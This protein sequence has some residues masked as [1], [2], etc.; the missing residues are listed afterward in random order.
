MAGIRRRPAARNWIPHRIPR[1]TRD[2]T[3]ITII[4]ATQWKSHSLRMMRSISW[5]LMW[6]VSQRSIHTV[7]PRGTR[8]LTAI[9]RMSRQVRFFAGA[10]GEVEA[11]PEGVDAEVCIRYWG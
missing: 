3:T 6:R 10:D 4:R 2:I 9:S 1:V 11:K 7:M 5:R 8:I